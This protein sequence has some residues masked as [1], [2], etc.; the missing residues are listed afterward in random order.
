MSPAPG[1]AVHRSRIDF[2]VYLLVAGAGAG[3]VVAAVDLFRTGRAPLAA[4]GIAMLVLVG[5]LLS[6]PFMIRY[7]IAPPFLRLRCGLFRWRISL[8]G[9]REVYPSRNPLSA[10]AASLDR[11]RIDFTVAG[12]KRFALVSPRDREAFFADL[13]AASP[14]LERSGDR[15]VRRAEG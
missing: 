8:E 12:R 11:L 15:L 7:E 6:F 3:M 5:V 14:G 1:A 13:A 10:P 9:I 2:W 4:L